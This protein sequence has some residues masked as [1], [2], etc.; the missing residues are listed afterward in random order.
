LWCF[1]VR[2]LGMKFILSEIEAL[3]C[4]EVFTSG[5]NQPLLIRGVDRNTGVVGE[6]VVKLNAAERMDANACCRELL[7]AQLAISF[8]LSVATPV[9][10][11][12]SEAFVSTLHP[13]PA[14]ADKAAKS[15]G[16]NF[17]T[18]YLPGKMIPMPG[19]LLTAAQQQ[20]AAPIF[21]FDAFISNPDRRT[22]K[23]NMLTDGHET[24]LIDHELA[25]SFL[26]L[27]PFLR[28]AEP[29]M[30]TK[31]DEEWLK[32]HYFYE[33]IKRKGINF[34]QFVSNFVACREDLLEQPKSF[35]PSEWMNSTHEAICKQLTTVLGEV[36]KF[37]AQLTQ[38]HFDQ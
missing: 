11:N 36:S 21:A 19:M 12:I 8:G 16:L 35:F 30:L 22:E 33:S 5:A 3:A 37:T 14:L 38:I 9:K 1:N 6:F 32:K 4:I 7:A 31:Q 34:E 17:G 28:P 27:L 15:I 13:Y 24:V 20:V 18:V 29:W 25:F 2:F 10:V 23:P 26:F